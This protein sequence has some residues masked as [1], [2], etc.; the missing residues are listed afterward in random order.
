VHCSPTRFDVH[1]NGPSRHAAPYGI[2]FAWGSFAES[3]AQ[4]TRGRPVADIVYPKPQSSV[5]A[6]GRGGRGTS[7]DRM[8]QR[9]VRPD[10]THVTFPDGVWKNVSVADSA[11][12]VFI[13]LAEATSTVEKPARS[14]RNRGTERILGRR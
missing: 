9:S 4:V 13:V 7:P 5:H 6:R 8:S 14:S 11:A 2:T 12:G 10:S 1:R 3:P